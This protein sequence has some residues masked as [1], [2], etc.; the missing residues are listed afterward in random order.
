VHGLK[1]EV[2]K[3]SKSAIAAVEKLGGS[4]TTVYHTRTG[5]QQLLNPSPSAIQYVYEPPVLAKDVEYYSN[6]HNRGYLSDKERFE[7]DFRNRRYLFSIEEYK[8]AAN[9]DFVGHVQQL[10][11][12]SDAQEILTDLKGKR[13]WRQMWFEQEQEKLTAQETLASQRWEQ[14]QW[15][16]DQPEDKRWVVVD[17]QKNIQFRALQ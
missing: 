4:V 2:S 14:Q 6:Q 8:K 17:E 9:S 1:I 7:R 12:V 13:A 11:S 15:F 3:A 5:L 16:E 10:Y